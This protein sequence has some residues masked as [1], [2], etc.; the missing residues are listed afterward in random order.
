M[1]KTSK[2]CEKVSS[3]HETELQIVVRSPEDK[4][5]LNEAEAWKVF[6]EFAGK[7]TGDVICELIDIRKMGN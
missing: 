6:Q 5:T 4:R 3:G 7:I 2:Y 1:F